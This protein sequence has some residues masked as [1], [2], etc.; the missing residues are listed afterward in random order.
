MTTIT[1]GNIRADGMVTAAGKGGV[2]LPSAEKNA[3]FKKLKALRENQTCFDCPNTRPTWA[4]VTYGVFLCLDCSATHRSLGVHLTFVRSADLDEW[5]Q[6]QID[7]MRL[8]GNANARQYFRKHGFTDLYGGKA[9]KKYTSKTAVNYRAELKKI[10]D[11]ETAKQRGEDPNMMQDGDAG[12]TSDLLKQLELGDEKKEQEEAQRKLA[13]AR[14]GHSSNV[15]VQPKLKLASELSGSSKLVIRKPA[16]GGLRKPTSSSVGGLRK[17]GTAS[18]LKLKTKPTG[19]PRTMALKLPVNSNSSSKEVKD[20]FELEDIET[21]QKAA[22]E[23]E[24]VVKQ[25]AAD[26]ELAKR[27][28]AELNNGTPKRSYSNPYAA[29]NTNSTVTTSI[30]ASNNI[31]RPANPPTVSKPVV[32]PATSTMKVIQKNGMQEN[33]ARLKGMTNDFFS[34]M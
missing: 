5:T 3:Q 19:K 23:T 32:T 11:R 28:Q 8:G 33:I 4:S 20:D 24:K 21:T 27:L 22:E 18:A 16:T 9:N 7:A 30:T 26:E 34:D 10:V 2:C 17:L 31:S 15:V 14:N 12:G 29:M 25:M 1:S 6:P 13:M